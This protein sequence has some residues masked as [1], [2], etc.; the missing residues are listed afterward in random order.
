[1]QNEV[2][3]FFVGNL[4]KYVPYVIQLCNPEG[5]FNHNIFY[6]LF[7]RITNPSER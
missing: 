4:Q 6:K 3:G 7:S 1:M 5:T 2:V